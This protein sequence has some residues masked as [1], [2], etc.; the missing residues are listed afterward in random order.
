MSRAWWLRSREIVATRGVIAYDGQVIT[1]LRRIGPWEASFEAVG[2]DTPLDIPKRRHWVPEQRAYFELESP[3]Q[4]ADDDG[5]FTSSSISAMIADPYLA[6]GE[7]IGG[8]I[9]GANERCFYTCS[10]HYADVVYTTRHRLVRMSCGATHVVLRE[11]L[12]STFR[13]TIAPE[14][15]DDLFRATGSRHHERLDLAIVDVRE[16]ENAAPFVWSTDQWEE[17]LADCILHARAT[18]EEFEKAIRGTQR[19]ASIFLEAGWQPVPEPPAP[20]VQIMDGSVDVDVMDNAGHAFSG[21]ASAY[22]A[23]YVQPERL[24]DAIKDL[25]QAIKLLLN[26][27][28]LASAGARSFSSTASLSRS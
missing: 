6:R 12:L 23:A 27:R 17:A 28:P 4:M 10:C 19:D 18:P 15:W 11:P 26:G 16:I 20:A 1:S 3:Y 14:E 9:H 13:Q 22:L 2:I 8:V 25:F 5:P 24:I 21:G 7:L